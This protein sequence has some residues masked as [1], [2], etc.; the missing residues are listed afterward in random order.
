MA[1]SHLQWRLEGKSHGVGPG[2][3]SRSDVHPYAAR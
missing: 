2:A 3:A 1:M